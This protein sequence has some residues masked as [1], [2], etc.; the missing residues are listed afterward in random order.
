MASSRS[1]PTGVFLMIPISKLS[2]VQHFMIPTPEFPKPVPHP[3]NC[4]TR[5]AARVPVLQTVAPSPATQAGFGIPP[6]WGAGTNAFG[7]KKPFMRDFMLPD[8]PSGTPD[9]QLPVLRLQFTGSAS[10]TRL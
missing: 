1:P 3:M 7:L 6:N 9:L 4:D 2:C 5:G 10:S 8:E